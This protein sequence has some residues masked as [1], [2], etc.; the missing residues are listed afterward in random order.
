MAAGN[1]RNGQERATG[2]ARARRRRRLLP[3]VAVAVIVVAVAGVVTGAVVIA[4]SGS[5]PAATA[6]P[7]PPLLPGAPVLT[8]PVPAPAA[9]VPELGFDVSH[10]QCGVKLPAGGGF[11]IVGITGGRP[12]SSNKCSAKQ[13]AWARTKPGH[14][15]YVNTGYPGT[16][17]PVA[18][19]RTIVDDAIAREHAAGAGQTAMWWLDVETVN[20]WRGTPQENAT[21]LDSMAARLL[22][23]GARV[24]IYSTPK[25]WAEVAG[26]WAPGLPVWYATGPG[27]QA[28][29]E[30]ACS[31]SFAGSQTAIVQWVQSNAGHQ[32]DHNLICADWRNR[33]GDL[34][35][36]S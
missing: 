1:E 34:L 21:V 29:A 26:S 28:D 18:Y 36:V 15:V 25:M 16:G 27:A 35:D 17:D 32:L 7:D 23:L 24:G 20:S 5:H 12:L 22:E 6:T 11:G 31:R 13:V 30:T 2:S 33:A 3:F 14:A 8:L 4:R 9:T 10:P 19:G